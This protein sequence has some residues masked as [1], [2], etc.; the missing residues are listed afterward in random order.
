MRIHH[1]ALGVAAPVLLCVGLAR[2]QM[3]PAPPPASHPGSALLAATGNIVFVPLRLAVTAVGAGLGGLTGWLTA[4]N[5]QAARDIWHLTDG[6][7]YLEPAT[8][9]GAEPVEIGDL[10]FRLHL[11]KP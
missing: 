9:Y 1:L 6:Q 3:Q 2:A 4:G 8:M 7:G 5:K 11:T 10:Q